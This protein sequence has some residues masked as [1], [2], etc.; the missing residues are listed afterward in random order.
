MMASADEEQ[1]AF[2]QE[3]HDLIQAHAETI[4]DRSNAALGDWVL[5]ANWTDMDTGDNFISRLSSPTLLLHQRAWPSPRGPVRR[6]GRRLVG[7]GK[8]GER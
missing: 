4:V 8:T 5:V 7:A 3:L 2:P 6:L 1:K